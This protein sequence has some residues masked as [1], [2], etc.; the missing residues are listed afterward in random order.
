M[1]QF[2]KDDIASLDRRY[3]ANLIN[4]VTGAKPANLVGTADADG[5]TNLAV[6]S[7]AVHIGANPPLVGLIFRPLGEVDRHTYDNIKATGLYTINHV[8]EEFTKEA[9]LTSAK[10]PRGVSEF[11]ACGFTAEFIE[12][13]PAPFVKESKVKVGLRFVGE[14]PIEMNG[15]ILLIGEIETISLPESSLR[16]DGNIDL[17]ECGSSCVVGL[18]TYHSIGAGKTYPYAKPEHTETIS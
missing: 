2:S 3:R 5:A 1:R 13:F 11:T 4:C 10:F 16:E 12:S 7:S 9:H 15:T 14:M 8:N 18:D 17:F 6:F